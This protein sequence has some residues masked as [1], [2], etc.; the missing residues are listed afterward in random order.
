MNKMIEIMSCWSSFSTASSCLLHAKHLKNIVCMYTQYTSCFFALHITWKIIILGNDVSV[1]SCTR[2][3]ARALLETNSNAA[4]QTTGAMGKRTFEILLNSISVRN[5][6][7]KSFFYIHSR[8]LISV[9]LNKCLWEAS[10]PHPGPDLC[11]LHSQ[12]FL[13]LNMYKSERASTVS[14][15]TLSTM[16]L[17]NAMINICPFT[18]FFIRSFFVNVLFFLIF[19][20]FIFTFLFSVHVSH[21]LWSSIK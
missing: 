21:I 4:K 20:F 18:V 15:W 17:A 13:H 16:W 3:I 14:L 11:C 6:S 5:S 1:S 10:P 7:R 19:F 2:T 8:W 9:A 12:F